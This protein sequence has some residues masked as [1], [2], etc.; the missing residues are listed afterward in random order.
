MARRFFQPFW[1]ASY[2]LSLYGLGYR[3]SEKDFNGEKK[4]YSEM[5]AA[6]QD[7]DKPVIFDVG[8]RHGEVASLF[9]FDQAEVHVFEPDPRNV[10]LLKK[11]FGERL[12]V[13]EAAVADVPGCD[14]LHF[15]PD[16]AQSHF[17]SLLPRALSDRGD[18]RELEVQIVTLDQYA[19]ERKIDYIDFL[20]ID[21]EG[22]E[23]QVLKGAKDLLARQAVKKL[24]IEIS[25]SSRIGGFCLRDVAVLLPQYKISKVLPHGLQPLAAPDWPEWEITEY[26]NFVLEPKQQ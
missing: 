2:R 26:A 20:K 23:Y 8:A 25:R 24:L 15:L 19:S 6:L 3:N 1:R 22:L 4:F 12:I 11:R 17:S 13:N 21:V 18:A 9:C 16:D 5:A 10:R 14:R 7:I